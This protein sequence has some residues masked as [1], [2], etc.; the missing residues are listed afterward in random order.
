MRASREIW[1]PLSPRSLA[2]DPLVVRR[3]E[4]G[5]AAEALDF[6][7]DVERVAG[8]ASHDGELGG[9]QLAR[10]VEDQVR[11]AELADVVQQRGAA[12]VARRPRVEPEHARQPDGDL[13]DAAAVAC[14]P[15]ALGVDD[16]GETERDR[17]E[18]VVVG[19][20]RAARGL[21]VHHGTAWLVVEFAPDRVGVADREQRVD[22]LRI[23]PRA[24]AV[25][26]HLAHRVAAALAEEDLGRLREAHDAGADRDR[27]AD[28]T[29]GWPP[30]S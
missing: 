30:P 11:D 16:L 1:V 29:L 5:E 3:G 2:V 27:V 8:V 19:V 12:E 20:E 4:V 25:A 6:A 13:R 18:P 21:V 14:R 10:L 7:K 23:E 26:A 15:R 9:V 22:E 24:T 17:V 28:Q